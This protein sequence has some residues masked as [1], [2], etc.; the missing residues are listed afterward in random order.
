MLDALFHHEWAQEILAGDF[1]GDEVFFRAP[2]YPYLLA[3]LYKLERREHRVRD[4][5]SARHRVAQ[6]RPRLSSRAPVFSL[7]ECRSRRES[8]PP[9]TGRSSTSKEICCSRRSSFFSISRSFSSSRSRSN[10]A[11]RRCSSSAGLV[12][13]LS[14]IARPSILIL[15]P[16]LPFVFRHAAAPRKGAENEPVR[17]YGRPL[18]S[19]AGSLVFIL[20]VLVRNFVVGRDFVPIASQGGVN[21]YIGNNPQSN[22]SQAMV[23]GARADLYGT[24]QGAIE[25]AEKD[26]GRKLKPSEV[27]N[28]YTRKAL[29]FIVTEPADAASLF[30]KKLYLFWAGIERSNDKYMQFFWK[31]YGLGRFPLPGFWLVGPF[32]LL[33]GALLIRRW[34]EYSLLYLFVL[35][36]M[37]GV[38]DLLRQRPVQRSPSP[39]FSSSSRRTRSSI[40]S[41]PRGRTARSFS[42]SSALLAVF[43]FA[44]DYDYVAFRGVRSIDEAVSHYEIA[45]AYLKTGDKDRA[46]SHFE[47]ARRDAAE[48]PDA[49]LRA[50]RRQHRLQPRDDLLGERALLARDRGARANPRRRSAVFP[51]EGPSRRFVRQ[52][53]TRGRRDRPLYEYA[54]AEPGRPPRSL[55][56]RGRSAG[57]RAISND[58]GRSSKR[59]CGNTGRRTEA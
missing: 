12:L 37:I 7:N 5:R 56:T 33:G 51:G 38:V 10:G 43:V 21:F 3:F 52:E 18:W 48:V 58:R 35:S 17:G 11:R 53:G 50:D 4:S 36:Y 40:C 13:G 49:E 47:E 31:R 2:F 1:W 25:L 22:G 23:P 45:N 30:F 54:A 6:R 41:R 44:V 46:L 9:S 8:S 15:V 27:S 57:G 34:R 26:A 32:A 39:R 28:Y 16:V 42:G 14:A 29:D 24:Y 55:R 20:P 59:S 19:S